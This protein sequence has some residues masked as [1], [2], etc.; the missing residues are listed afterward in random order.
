M[1]KLAHMDFIKEMEW[2]GMIHNSTPGLSQI[3]KEKESKIREGMRQMGLKDSAFY[4]SMFLSNMFE[5]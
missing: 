1:Y 3:L 5:T 2:R 4:L